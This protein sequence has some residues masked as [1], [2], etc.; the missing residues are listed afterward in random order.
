MGVTEADWRNLA[1]SALQAL[2]F[3]V[4]KKAFIQVRDTR[5]IDLVAAIE[6]SKKAGKP[7]GL[8]Q[9]EILAFEVRHTCVHVCLLSRMLYLVMSGFASLR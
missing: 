7:A 5:Y 6:K 9:A 8:L 4:A 1:H 3:T 2:E